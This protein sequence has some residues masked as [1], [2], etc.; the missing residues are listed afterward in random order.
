MGGVGVGQT[1]AS[2]SHSV[3]VGTI[4]DAQVRRGAA[5]HN[6]A[7]DEESEAIKRRRAIV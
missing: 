6:V 5:G 7:T 3:C 2:A 1:G 4:G